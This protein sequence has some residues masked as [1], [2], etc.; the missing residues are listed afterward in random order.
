MNLFTK[1]GIKKATKS[2]FLLFFKN[3]TVYNIVWQRIRIIWQ[4]IIL[5]VIDFIKVT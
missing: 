4:S 1:E 3:E 5:K 2:I